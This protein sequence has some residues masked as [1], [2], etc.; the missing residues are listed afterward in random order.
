MTAE[1]IIQVDLNA[2][3]WNVIGSYIG[4]FIP[5][6]D[7]TKGR[8]PQGEIECAC[9]KVKTVRSTLAWV[10]STQLGQGAGRGQLHPVE[11][12]SRFPG[13]LLTPDG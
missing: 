8:E 2:N 13:V 3:L 1:G 9:P 5:L 12:M 11:T 4:S 10:N 7:K 6:R